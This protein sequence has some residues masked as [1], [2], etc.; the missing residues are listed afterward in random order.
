VFGRI[1]V[2][3]MDRPQVQANSK[4]VQPPPRRRIVPVAVAPQDQAP[5]L[6]AFDAE[7][8]L[9]VPPPPAKGSSRTIS[10]SGQGRRIWVDIHSSIEV[11]FKEVS[12]QVPARAATDVKQASRLADTGCVPQVLKQQGL[13]YKTWRAAMQQRRAQQD[14]AAG[15]QVG[16]FAVRV[17]LQPAGGTVKP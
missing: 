9:V 15:A 5:S 4:A 8:P 11:K 13:E 1:L 12:N 3:T 10:A 17:S 7:Q 14:T 16:A 6:A 2:G